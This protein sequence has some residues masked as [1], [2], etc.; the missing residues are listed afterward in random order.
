MV[1]DEVKM[2]LADRSTYVSG[3]KGSL[4]T[5]RSERRKRIFSSGSM[6]LLLPQMMRTGRES[7]VEVKQ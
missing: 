5:I 1:T 7:R 6:L 3:Q 4:G 2:K